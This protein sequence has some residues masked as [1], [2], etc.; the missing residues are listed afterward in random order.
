LS[1]ASAPLEP[2][3][4]CGCGG[5]KADMLVAIEAGTSY[6]EIGEPYPF[7]FGLRQ[8]TAIRGRLADALIRH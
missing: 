6:S 5:E 4:S 1:L 3:P 8:Q 7:I 2:T